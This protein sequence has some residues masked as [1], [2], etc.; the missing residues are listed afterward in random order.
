M[1][2]FSAGFQPALVTSLFRWQTSSNWIHYSLINYAVFIQREK[3]LQSEVVTLNSTCVAAYQNINPMS[4]HF[5]LLWEFLII[6]SPLLSHSSAQLQGLRN[7]SKRFG[8]HQFQL[9][10]FIPVTRNTENC[11]LCSPL[12]YHDLT[13]HNQP[14]SPQLNTAGVWGIKEEER[15]GAKCQRSLFSYSWR[16]A[17]FS[18]CTYLET[19]SLNDPEAE[20]HLAIAFS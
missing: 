10:G 20:K 1:T 17:R 9:T 7:Q 16:L 15:S 14:F 18:S 11:T 8:A 3:R 5:H 4:M 2:V 13:T 6:T 12:A 19:I